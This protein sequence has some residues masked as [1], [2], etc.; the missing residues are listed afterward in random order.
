VSDKKTRFV[1][2]SLGKEYELFS[3]REN[4]AGELY[5]IFKPHVITNP[6]GQH[7][8]SRRMSVHGSPD[9]DDGSFLVKTTTE[10]SDK[11]NEFAYASILPSASSHCMVVCSQVAQ[12]FAD[13]DLCT[14]KPRDP[15]IRVCSGLHVGTFFYSLAVSRYGLSESDFH[16]LGLSVLRVPFKKIELFVLSGLF[17]TGATNGSTHFYKMSQP[18]VY[19]GEPDIWI[20]PPGALDRPQSPEPHQIAYL[21]GDDIELMSEWLQAD[22]DKAT[23]PDGTPLS[24]AEIE[25]KKRGYE[26]Y[27]EGPDCK[28]TTDARVMQMVQKANPPKDIWLPPAGSTTKIGRR[29]RD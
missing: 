29:K 20:K 17:R 11:K 8:T 15:R 1:V 9:S 21:V 19:D 24:P 25:Y 5:I 14:A 27:W 7:V 6:V 26:I 18:S 23:Y 4:P 22:L 28:T 2:E 12:A 10:Y 3:V 16:E 13:T